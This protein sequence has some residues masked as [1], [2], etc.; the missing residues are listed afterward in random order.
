[1]C[2]LPVY[3]LLRSFRLKACEGRG[4]YVSYSQHTR[5]APLGAPLVSQSC[6]K[7]HA[8]GPVTGSAQ[9]AEKLKSYP[10]RKTHGQVMAF[11]GCPSRD[12]NDNTQAHP[13]CI[14]CQML[15]AVSV[16]ETMFFILPYSFFRSICP[17]IC[18]R[19][20]LV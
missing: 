8:K 17:S 6:R 1:M 9:P 10:F 18:L 20:Y 7:Q 5:L 4:C 14:P 2:S 12:P 13:E 16:E 15:F 11:R 19:I 3:D